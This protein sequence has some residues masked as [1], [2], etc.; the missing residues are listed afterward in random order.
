MWENIYTP[1]KAVESG[2]IQVSTSDESHTLFLKD[3]GSLWG[4]GDTSLL[5]VSRGTDRTTI[6]RQII[7]TGVELAICGYEFS[8]F[9][10]E[11]GSLWGMGNNEYGQLGLGED[12]PSYVQDPTQIIPADVVDVCAN[13]HTLF[14]K[15]DGSLWGMG[16]NLEGQLGLGDWE[17]KYFPTL[18]KPGG[19]SAKTPSW[20]PSWNVGISLIIDDH[21]VGQISHVRPYVTMLDLPDPSLHFPISEAN[22]TGITSGNLQY[23]PN[24]FQDINQSATIDTDT[25]PLYLEEIQAGEQA[26]LSGWLNPNLS[27][28]H[29]S[30]NLGIIFSSI[31]TIRPVGD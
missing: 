29:S 4:M 21:H 20:N 11:N 12:S 10:M 24:R 23:G 7:E 30:L 2:V 9:I 6:P 31:S 16:Y 19:I 13:D 26:T 18:I 25:Q 17:D 22:Q 28:S 3:D 8:L 14:V 27:S 1:Q 5:G 15:K